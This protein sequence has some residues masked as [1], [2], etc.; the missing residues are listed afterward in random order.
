MSFLLT[1]VRRQPGTRALARLA[2]AL[3]TTVSFASS[4]NSSGTCAADHV[5]RFT[6]ADSFAAGRDSKVLRFAL[7]DTLP[8]LPRPAPSGVKVLFDGVDEA[9]GEAKVLEKSYSPVSL[10]STRGFFDLLVKAY[11]PRPGGGVGG[12]LCG[13]EP[14]DTAAMKV[15]PARI[16]HGSEA[17]AGRWDSLGFVGGGTGVAPFVQ[18]IR[19]LLEGH[20]GDAT[21]LSLLSVNREEGDVLMRAEIDSLAARFPARFQVTYL[22]TRQYAPPLPTGGAGAW[23]GAV[24][25]SGRG[26]VE[27]ARQ[28]LPPPS[29]SRGGGGT[30]MVMV[31]G[32]DGFV[33]HWSG[34]VTRVVDAATRKKRKVQ[35]PVTGLLGEA[36]YSEAEVYKF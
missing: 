16:I 26:S 5:F 36:G 18:I 4:S 21:Q 34:A 2:V 1:A 24:V 33:E 3:S 23:G 19:E 30:T 11:P 32:T 13:L 27:L 9:T 14:G 31:C 8:S 28:A 29:S 22:F 12:F 25:V 10:P 20:P 35:G 7:P 15:K 6:L 17:V